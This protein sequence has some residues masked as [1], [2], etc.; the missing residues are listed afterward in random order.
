MKY[1]TRTLISIAL[2][3]SFGLASIAPASADQAAANR[4][5]WL[6]IAA[7][8]AGIA[9]ASNVSHKNAQANAI[10]G[11]T[12]DGSTVYAD[13]HVVLPNGQ[14]YYPGNQNQSVACNNGQC[15]VDGGYNNNSYSPGYNNN[16]NNGNYNNSNY[17]NGWNGQNRWRGR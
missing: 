4:N 1:L 15:S 2:A 14:S 9:I 5:T 6:G 13:G 11:Y 3:A 8:V 7:A 17:N 10:E 12:G 16:Y